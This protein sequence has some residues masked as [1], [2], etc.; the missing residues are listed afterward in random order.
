M[1]GNMAVTAM[2]VVQDISIGRN[3]R[4]DLLGEMG[5]LK[6]KGDVEAASYVAAGDSGIIHG[7]TSVSSWLATMGPILANGKQHMYRSENLYIF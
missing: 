1:T 4:T 7:R 6:V 2:A 3:L 5:K